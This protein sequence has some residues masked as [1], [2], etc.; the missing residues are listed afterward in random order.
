MNDGSVQLG[1]SAD[2]TMTKFNILALLRER[3]ADIHLLVEERVP[4]FQED[5]GLGQYTKLVQAFFGFLAPVEE[6]LSE[7][8]TLQDP[9]LALQS[10]LKSQLLKEDLL[11]L[12]CDPAAVRRCERLPRLDTFPRGIGCLYVLEGSTLGSQIISRRLE[13]KLHLNEN[14]GAS[15]FNAYGG[16]VGSRWMEFKRFVL[17]SVRPEHADEVVGAARDTF[18][19]L[20]EWLESGTA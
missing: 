14:S 17:A 3:T 20:Y 9:D 19:C 10:R 18:T 1:L 4:V 12:G 16:L 8:T 13:E 5:F 11:I 6:R 7:L 2:A 15:Y